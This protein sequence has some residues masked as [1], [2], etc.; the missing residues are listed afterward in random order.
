MY[1]IA[2]KFSSGGPYEKH[3]VAT[4][5]LGNH[6]SILETI[7]LKYR[8]MK[9]SQC[10]LSTTNPTW[11]FCV[12]FVIHVY[13]PYILLLTQMGII[14]ENGFPLSCKGEN[15]SERMSSSTFHVS[16]EKVRK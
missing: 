2:A 10:H 11:I 8:K 9:L 5:N 13:L 6:L 16:C 14:T 15:A 12:I 4:W 1:K 3:V 7:R